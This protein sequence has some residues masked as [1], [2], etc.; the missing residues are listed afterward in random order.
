M[1][2]FKTITLLVVGIYKSHNL[3]YPLLHK[4]LFLNLY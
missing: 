3:Q 2:L 1:K 4:E